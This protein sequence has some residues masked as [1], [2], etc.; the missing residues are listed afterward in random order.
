MIKISHL[1][2]NGSL[3]LKRGIKALTE[4]SCLMFE[5]L[6]RLFP[7][8]DTC[9]DSVSDLSIRINETIKFYLHLKLLPPL[10]SLR[11]SNRSS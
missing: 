9:D 11:N 3:S 5:V 10:F 8:R 1:T 6:A 7:T 2:L 4:Y